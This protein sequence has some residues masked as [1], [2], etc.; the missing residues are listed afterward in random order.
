[1]AGGWQGEQAGAQLLVLNKRKENGFNIQEELQ[2][3]FSQKNSKA[4]KDE[5]STWCGTYIH[6]PNKPKIPHQWEFQRPPLY[7]SLYR[8]LCLAH[9]KAFEGRKARTWTLSCL[10]NSLQTQS[11]RIQLASPCF[12]CKIQTLALSGYIELLSR[13]F[14]F[15][16]PRKMSDKEK[17]I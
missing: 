3:Y 12:A 10:H 17:N 8:S 2:G 6:L 5:I 4:A 13:I 16:Y 1:M 7:R 9:S 11:L 14:D 15:T